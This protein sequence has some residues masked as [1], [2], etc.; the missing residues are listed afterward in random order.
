[1]PGDASPHRRARVRAARSQRWVRFPRRRPGPPPS[2]LAVA[3]GGAGRSHRTGV[4]GRRARPHLARIPRGAGAARGLDCARLSRPAFPSAGRQ[5]H[6]TSGVG[7]AWAWSTLS[8]A[9]PAPA[10]PELRAR[11]RPPRPAGLLAPAG[12]GARSP[13]DGEE[14]DRGHPR[15]LPNQRAAAPLTCS[16]FSAAITTCSGS[17]AGPGSHPSARRPPLASAPGRR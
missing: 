1:M 11:A 17:R 5:G 7:A 16:V 8:A 10:D 15:P 6:S 4:L 9:A 13:G 14:G 12:S 3:L 2:S